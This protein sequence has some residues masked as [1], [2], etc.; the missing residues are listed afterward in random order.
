V[1]SGFRAAADGWDRRG[2]E[3]TKAAT[4]AVDEAMTVA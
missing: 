4:A 3:D 1:M 2:Q